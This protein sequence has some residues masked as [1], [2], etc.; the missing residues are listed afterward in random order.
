M[1]FDHRTNA[2]LKRA[3]DGMCHPLLINYVSSKKGKKKK[4]RGTSDF[5][6]VSF[7]GKSAT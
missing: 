4:Q 2:W 1:T 3:S 7:E 5:A 6:L